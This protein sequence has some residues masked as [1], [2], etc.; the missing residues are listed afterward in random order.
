M[1]LNKLFAL[2]LSAI[3]LFASCQEEDEPDAGAASLTLNSAAT[4]T[5]G[6][7][8]QTI[9]IEF[10]TNRAWTVKTDVVWVSL[11]P[12]AGEASSDA[13]KVTATVL[14]N[15]SSERVATITL[16]NGE[17]SKEIS[18]TQEAVA[19]TLENP[20]DVVGAIAKC[21]EVGTEATKDDFYV[22]GK[23]CRVKKIDV[24]KDGVA[25]FWI[26]NDGTML[27]SQLYVYEAFAFDGKRFETTE[28]IKVGDNVV[29]A[30]KLVNY[31][32][33]TPEVYTGGRLVSVNGDTVVPS[34]IRLDVTEIESPAVAF[35]FPVNVFSN[36]SW[37]AATDSDF[38]T[39]STT[40]GENN[41]EVTV[42]IAENS[43]V[44]REARVAEVT[45]T[46]DGR[47]AVL[48]IRQLEP[49][50]KPAVAITWEEDDWVQ[51]VGTLTFTDED[52]GITIVCGKG[53]QNDP[54]F[55]DKG[56]VRV[57][58]GGTIT[59]TSDTEMEYIRVI[60][61]GNSERYGE[62]TADSGVIDPQ[63]AGDTE[64]RWSGSAKKVVLTLGDTA[65]YGNPDKKLQLD[66]D[67]FV[68][69]R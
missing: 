67:S 44:A 63:A 53:T 51:G 48:K 64:V 54:V 34:Y 4:V 35:D 6:S 49:D 26:S 61:A 66:V 57:Y 13:Q 40:S 31:N 22:K 68:I 5:V 41:A 12:T 42:S 38:V 52:E 55:K 27:S 56:A 24:V 43:S 14:S 15:D 17:I 37:T 69:K 11:N 16:S 8:T 33:D 65:C 1:K 39:L 30:G 28:Q 45:F 29:V 32:D 10:T 21:L 2:A 25:T 47:T 7:E 36:T 20:Y 23:V 62:V 58:A 60:L 59:I 9:E 50:E 18:L 3:T 19:G 46:A